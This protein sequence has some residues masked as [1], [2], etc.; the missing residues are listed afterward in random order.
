[1]FFPTAPRLHQIL[2]STHSRKPRTKGKGRR[3][4]TAKY[5][6]PAAN[7]VQLQAYNDVQVQAYY[8][9][10]RWHAESRVAQLPSQDECRDETHT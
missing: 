5:A 1:M 3:R 2:I 6:L 4:R 10:T 9:R 7:V 8:G